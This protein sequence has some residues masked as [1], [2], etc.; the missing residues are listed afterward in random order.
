MTK[1]ITLYDASAGLNTKLDPQRLLFGTR[2]SP[3]LIELS[4][5]VNVTIDDRG[6]VSIRNGGILQL[7]GEFHSL[8]CAGGHCFYIQERESDAALMRYSGGSTSVGIRSGLTKNLRMAFATSGNDTFYANGVQ[9]GYIRNGVSSAWPV[10]TYYGAEADV[11]F[12]SSVP[13]AQH[14]AFL[15]GGQE[16]LG[17]GGAIFS[18][19]APF[20]YGLFAIGRGNVASF[21]SPITM[22]APVQAGFF[23]SDS[24]QTWFFR[25]LEGNWYLFRQE[26][27]EDAPALVGS[28][29]HD[30]VKLSDAGLEREGFG[31][32]WASTKGVC[33]GTDDGSF[34]NLT[35]EK[36]SYPSGYISG[37]CLIKDG[38]V[39]HSA[40]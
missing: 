22:I 24:G 29:A 34:I 3:G 6:L 35:E 28:L 15:Q 10:S 38:N 11:Q 31:R 39:I 1:P 32:I 18:N 23:A 8:Y 40:P 4:Q 9:N 16:L 25:R 36:I 19:H 21:K 13:V 17:V 14:I 33:L 5:A 37:A 30:L 7:S 12:A 26:L 27:V 2:E 20:Q